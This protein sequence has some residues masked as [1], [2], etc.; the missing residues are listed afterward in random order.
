MPKKV[1]S[2]RPS[3]LLA[4]NQLEQKQKEKEKR[5]DKKKELLNSTL[6]ASSDLMKK[7]EKRKKT[8]E[9]IQNEQKELSNELVANYNEQSALIVDLF[10]KS[11]LHS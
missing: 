3:L 8:M 5:R 2:M 4:R 1:N 11:L 6:E 7:I 9:R 10:D